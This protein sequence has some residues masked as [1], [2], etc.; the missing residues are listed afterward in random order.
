MKFSKCKYVK[1]RSAS[2]LQVRKFRHLK[3]LVLWLQKEQ[4]FGRYCY[5]GCYCLPEGSHEISSGGYGKPIDNI[6]GACR[7]FKW[8]YQCLVREH[9][10]ATPD[11]SWGDAGKQNL[12]FLISDFH[13]LH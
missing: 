4:K 10:E 11:S 6:D 2:D 7:D 9:N 1:S 13:V 5:Y 3:L 8:C 12:F